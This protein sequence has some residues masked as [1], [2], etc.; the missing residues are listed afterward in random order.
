LLLVARLLID[1]RLFLG[2]KCF[3]R[4]FG[5]TWTFLGERDDRTVRQEDDILLA[6]G[7]VRV[8]VDVMT[9]FLHLGHAE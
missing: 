2:H 1:C 5:K 6:S 9:I 4:E 8:E 7:V 3:V